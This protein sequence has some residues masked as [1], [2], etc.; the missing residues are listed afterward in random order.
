MDAASLMTGT[1]SG[2]GELASLEAK[3][4]AD[5]LKKGIHITKNGDFVRVNPNSASVGAKIANLSNF[6]RTATVVGLVPTAI[7]QISAGLDGTYNA[8]HLVDLTITGG[9]VA[10]G[11]FVTG[12]V[13]VVGVI[14]AGI[15]YGG[16]RLVQ[17]KAIDN[18]INRS[19]GWR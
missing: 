4:R 13:A 7:S 1:V 16:I 15:V 12:P 18:A 14:G 5:F 11:V 17:G 8:S 6:G 3:E 2:M 19:I 10:V 9:L